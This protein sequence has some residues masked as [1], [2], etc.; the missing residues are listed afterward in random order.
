MLLLGRV[1]A[2]LQ[3]DGSVENK[4]IFN[5]IRIGAEITDTHKLEFIAGLGCSKI[6]LNKTM[7]D[8]L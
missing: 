6:G 7:N 4:I 3:T 8:L 1:I 2:V 5:R